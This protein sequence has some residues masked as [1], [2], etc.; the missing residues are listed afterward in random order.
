LFNYPHTIDNGLGERLTFL[1]RVTTP[2]GEILEVE[3]VVRPGMGPPMH[4]HYHQ[5]EGLTVVQGR[6]GYQRK[7]EEPQFAEAGSTV[8]FR[9]GDVHRF[10]NAGDDDAK[11]TGYVKPPDSFEYFLDGIYAAQKKSGAPRPD[12]FDSAFLMRRYR[13]EFGMAEIPAFVQTF[14][15]P[16]VVLIGGLAGKYRKFA[17][18]PPPAR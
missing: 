5:E 14:V 18:A 11:L 4:V 7:G 3:G 9:P 1:R 2:E 13:S 16:I 10:W 6:I 8:V 15:F 12:M 17:D